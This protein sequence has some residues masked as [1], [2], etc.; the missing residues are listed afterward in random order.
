MIQEVTNMPSQRFLQL[1]LSNDN[2]VP[3]ADLKVIVRCLSADLSLATEQL[4]L[5][6]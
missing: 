1:S 6:E 4:T 5:T 2:Q 3:E